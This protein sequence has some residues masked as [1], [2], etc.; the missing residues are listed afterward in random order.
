MKSVKWKL[1]TSLFDLGYECPTGTI[2][3]ADHTCAKGGVCD[4]WDDCKDKSD[5]KDCTGNTGL[6]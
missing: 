6:L 2:K 5:E 3:C 1:I 4:G